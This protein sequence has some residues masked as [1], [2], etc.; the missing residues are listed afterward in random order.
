M[1]PIKESDYFV[2]WIVFFL[3]ATVGGGI[4]GMFVGSVLGG[5]LGVV[6]VPLET[7]KF[8]CTLAGFVVA[9]LASFFTFRLVVA[10][11]IV[12]KVKAAMEQQN[13]TYP[14]AP[15]VSQP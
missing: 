15:P 10:K 13:A 4:L 9:V 7:I 6:H 3:T 12:E 1:K 2:A 11:M 14:S 5:T 8:I